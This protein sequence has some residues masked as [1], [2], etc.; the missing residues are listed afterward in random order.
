M[1]I[2]AL[3][4]ARGGSKSIPHK[5]IRE[6][7]GKP[8]IYWSLHAA[9]GC[10]EI[11]HVYVAT[12]DAR[13]SE[14][15][16]G[17]AF[18]KVSVIGRSP[19]TATDTASTESVL[20]EFATAVP[21]DLIVLIQATSPLV[22]S[23]DLSAGITKVASGDCD[24][25]LS[26]VIQKRFLWSTTDDGLVRSMNYDPVSR[27]RRQDFIGYQVENGAFYVMRT[28]GLLATK[29]RLHGRIASC[30]MAS[31]S[32][33][34]IDEPEDWEVVHS[35]LMR[36]SSDTL[37]LSLANVRILLTDVDGVLTDAGMYYADGGEEL[38]KFNTRD[39]KGLELL[40]N[41]GIKVGIVTSEKT[42]IVSRR[43]EKLKLDF[44][45]QGVADKVAEVSRIL[46]DAGLGWENLA[47]IGD[48]LNDLGVL[49]RAGV[50]ATPAD[51]M[52][53]CRRSA[54]YVCIKNGGE[55]CVREICDLILGAQQ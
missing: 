39:G 13:I 53:A 49:S 12:D 30:P 42:A 38:K 6:I 35:F 7:G 33:T 45:S 48:D 41:K 40:R 5:N 54:Q 15:V 9:N 50:S 16:K 55:G 19:D 29:V 27:P 22:T 31:N 24:T 17:F 8:L 21:S 3:I 52:L 37:S 25:A 10:P 26:T 32:Y 43:G 46:S 11:S 2:V 51:A 14:V 20:L 1:N 34:E 23:V 28:E 44:V 4:P 36:R 47:Y 18:P